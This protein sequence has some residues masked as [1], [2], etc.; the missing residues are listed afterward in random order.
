MVRTMQAAGPEVHGW[1][2]QFGITVRK[3]W[4][5]ACVDWIL[6][7]EVCIDAVTQSR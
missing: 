3:E 4:L 5:D 1:L 6:N 2:K 7:E